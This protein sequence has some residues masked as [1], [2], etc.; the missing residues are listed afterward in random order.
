MR[1]NNI[2]YCSSLCQETDWPL[3]KLLCGQFNDFL[4]R[5]TAKHK[6]AIFFPADQSKPNFV[7]VELVT[8]HDEDDGDWDLANVNDWLRQEGEHNPLLQFLPIHRNVTLGLDLPHGIELV[9]RDGFLKDGSSENSSVRRMTQGGTSHS[10]R[11][12]MLAYGREKPSFGSWRE[13]P[14]DDLDTTDLKML[15]DYFIDYGH[16]NI[17]RL[18]R[19]ATEKVQGV[20]VYCDADMTSLKKPRFEAVEVPVTHAI[21]K[22]WDT[23]R[24]QIAKRIGMPLLARNMTRKPEETDGGG[25]SEMVALHI[26]CEEPRNTSSGTVFGWGWAHDYWQMDSMS[27]VV[28]REDKQPLSTNELKDL[29]DWCTNELRPLFAEAHE[30]GGGGVHENV[31]GRITRLAFQRYKDRQGS[32]AGSG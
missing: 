25:N 29:C 22:N 28:V 18:Q 16:E 11:G 2:S 6:R 8:Q 12:P 21:L 26:Q 5:P 17:E 32:D 4:N 1:C 23:Q 13:A 24:S 27:T 3:H 7:W 15:H 10:W 9:V 30:Q 31:R 19:A 20:I 14:H